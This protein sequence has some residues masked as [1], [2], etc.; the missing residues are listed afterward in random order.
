MSGYW[1]PGYY[2]ELRKK[3]ELARKNKQIEYYNR[4]AKCHDEGTISGQ[5]YPGDAR[6]MN[7]KD[8]EEM[9]KRNVIMA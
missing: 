1:N 6:W 5:E 2:K 9:I 8:R 4:L 3:E 7:A